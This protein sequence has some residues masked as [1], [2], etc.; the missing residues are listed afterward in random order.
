[1]ELTAA[2]LDFSLY[3]FWMKIW[4]IKYL[5]TKFIFFYTGNDC[6]LWT[7]RYLKQKL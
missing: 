1:V 5:C 2:E 3:M 7:S 4:G 6:A